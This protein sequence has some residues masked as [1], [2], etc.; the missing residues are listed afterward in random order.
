MPRWAATARASWAIDAGLVDRQPGAA[1]PP[2]QGAAHRGLIV[3]DGSRRDAVTVVDED[4]AECSSA[5]RRSRDPPR[6]RLPPAWPRRSFLHP[7]LVSA[8]GRA[9]PAAA[10]AGMR[11]LVGD[12]LSPTLAELS[13][14]GWPPIGPLREYGLQDGATDP[15]G[16][17]DA[18]R[19]RRS[20]R[21]SFRARAGLLRAFSF[22]ILRRDKSTTAR[23]ATGVGSR[24]VWSGCRAYPGTPGFRAPCSPDPA[25]PAGR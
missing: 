7:L 17:F 12:S 22:A 14:I 15:V 4:P 20:R 9:E 25:G 19:I 23:C 5:C 13:D 16:S 1:R 21:A 11:F 24:A 10:P 3:A 18:A 2:G 8:R 6:H